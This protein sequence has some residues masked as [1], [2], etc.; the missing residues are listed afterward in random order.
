MAPLYN[1][2]QKNQ[3]ITL[4]TDVGP[5][6]DGGQEAARYA[7]AAVR[8]NN[9]G[10]DTKAEISMRCVRKIRK[11]MPGCGRD[12]E[13]HSRLGARPEKNGM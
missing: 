2:P 6:Y 11:K 10:M 5:G 13:E 12:M 1:V 7:K 9:S 4:R 3:I 8:R